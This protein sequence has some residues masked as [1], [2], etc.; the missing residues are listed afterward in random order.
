[1]KILKNVVSDSLSSQLPVHGECLSLEKK[2]I[3]LAACIMYRR[4]TQTLQI[5]FIFVNDFDQ[6]PRKIR[7]VHK[8]RVR[9]VLT[10]PSPTWAAPKDTSFSTE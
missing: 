8:G 10:L 1:M 5:M 6:S 3:I 7:G 2:K 9:G 4:F